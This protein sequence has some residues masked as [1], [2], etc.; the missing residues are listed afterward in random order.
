MKIFLE[1]EL[2]IIFI[3]LTILGYTAYTDWKTREI[4]DLH[5]FILIS[6]SF[7]V[8]LLRIIIY[9]DSITELF[10]I[11]LVSII[12]GIVIVLFMGFLGFWGGAD[13]LAILS[14]SL[15][16]PYPILIPNFY[17]SVLNSIFIYFP[18]SLTI[19]LNSALLQLPI[20]FLIFFSNAINYLKNPEMYFEP[21]RSSKIEKIFS[22]FLGSPKMI[23]NIAFMNPWFYNFMEEISIPFLINWTNYS[24]SK[25]FLRLSSEQLLRFKKYSNLRRNNMPHI[26]FT[27]PKV[28]KMIS[29][30]SLIEHRRFSHKIKLNS[31]EKDLYDQRIIIDQFNIQRL[32]SYLW[33]QHSLPFVFFIFFGLI[34]SIVGGNILFFILSLL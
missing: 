18:L 34:L 26:S 19:I 24:L 2:F 31:P 6:F 7:P 5:W 33:I 1:F 12:F 17:S 22:S 15:M 20:P 21:R 10:L 27:N 8:N 30:S 14:I 25:P 23:Q 11:S 28:Q 16:F 9:W 32:Y 4:S 3:S 13:L 29:M